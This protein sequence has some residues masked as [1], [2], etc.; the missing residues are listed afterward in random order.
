MNM[1]TTIQK[2]IEVINQHI[3]DTDV[4]DI[5][6]KIVAIEMKI[7]KILTETIMTKNLG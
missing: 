2:V 5:I 1:M 7:K 3:Q 6:V 4:D